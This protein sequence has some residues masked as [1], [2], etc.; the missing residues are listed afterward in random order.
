MYMYYTISMGF[1][2]VFIKTAKQSTK[3][4]KELIANRFILTNR[5]AEGNMLLTDDGYQKIGKSDVF[6]FSGSGK[7]MHLIYATESKYLCKLSPH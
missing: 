1:H 4:L 2:P 5:S 3:T 6:N 7:K